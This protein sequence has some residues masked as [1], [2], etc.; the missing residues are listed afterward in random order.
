M[1]DKTSTIEK[2]INILEEYG[3]KINVSSFKNN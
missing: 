2:E 1:K 3:S